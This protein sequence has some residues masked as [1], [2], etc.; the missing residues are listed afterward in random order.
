MTHDRT[1]RALILT[2]FS[3]LIVAVV[4]FAQT[5]ISL[6]SARSAGL[7]GAY[8]AIGDDV[9]SI[10]SN[11][12]GLM[13]LKRTQLVGSYTRYFSGA[14]IPTLQ[15][16]S[17][18][19]S[20]YNWSKFF[21]ALGVS[22]FNH[23][24]YNQQMGSLVIGRELWR[25]KR[26]AR[27]AAAVN[28]DLYRVDYNDVN[29]SD[30]FDPNDPL[31]NNG[32]SKMAYG[33]DFSL[34]AEYGPVSWGLR[35]YNLNEPEISL[36][37]GA[38]GGTLSRKVR[39]GLSYNIMD[40]VTPAIEV[41]VP[42]TSNPGVADKTSFALGAESWFVK[43]MIGA[44]MGFNSMLSS[45]HD[46]RG[47]LFTLG[48]SFRSRTDW[49]AGI[50]Y[51]LQ[52]PID[53]PVEVGQTHKISFG[54]G[55]HKPTRVIT[56]L[57]VV[58]SSVEAVPEHVTPG[59]EA[60][61]TLKI[62]NEGDMDAHDFPMS[63]YYFA[64]GKPFVAAR[65]TVDELLA[66]ETKE[67]VLKFRP[68]KSGYYD[69]FA[70]V[71]DKGDRAPAVH[72]KVLEYDLENNTGQTRLACFGPPVMMGKVRTS[73]DELEISTI[74]KVKEET[75][76]VPVIFFDK[77]SSSLD[78]GRFDATLR[79]I[80]NRLK[81]NPG[82]KIE[83]RG[84]YDPTTEADGGKD[85]ALARARKI[86][87]YFVSLG[88]NP[89]QLIVIESGYD[90]AAE[91][92]KNATP[93]YRSMISGENRSVQLSVRLDE[94]EHVCQYFYPEGNIQP[95]EEDYEGCLSALQ[96]LV[97]YLKEN[98]DVNVVFKGVAGCG[99]D[100]CNKEA[101][102]RAIEFRKRAQKAV[103]EWLGSRLLVLASEWVAEDEVARV[104]I[105]LNGD[106][107][108]FRPR[109]SATGRGSLEFSELGKMEITID[110]IASAVGLDSFAVT[111]VEDG[112]KE[113]FAV[114]DAGEGAPPRSIEWGGLGNSGQ[115]P[116]PGKKYLID[117]YAEDRFGQSI[118]AKSDPISVHV[119]EQEER[120]ELFIISFNFGKAEATSQYLEARVEALADKLIERAKYLGP[121][122]RI[123]ATVIGHTD[124]IGSA[125]A[126][127]E[128]SLERAKKEFDRLR[129]GIMN[130]LDLDSSE[131][132]DEWLKAHRV[133]LSYAGESY[134]DPMTVH[135][136]ENGYWHSEL[137]GDNAL[138]EGRLVNRRVVL[139]IL[140]IKR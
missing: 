122:V 5:D 18:Y 12:A 22:Y 93:E 35:A 118:D 131:E 33:G 121:N 62:A 84:Y 98:P 96:I 76:M 101:F 21:F 124:I 116:E 139:E 27:I 97:P 4:A 41:E 2:A 132:L 127:E 47:S 34:L 46:S 40:Y 102:D 134:N 129:Y 13:R 17:F 108:I 90:M 67:V 94:D 70:S 8:L 52:I 63:L 26:K 49:D 123:K 88:V 11:P 92:V 113:P 61:I 10:A 24:I 6:E 57:V 110:S 73:R 75:P 103:P 38:E 32:Y 135:R 44:R 107:L 45:D 3:V 60:N 140:T 87:D 23:D 133:E 25:H 58:P 104:E 64:D 68:E 77:A 79:T 28:I 78:K 14:N 16:G 126:N 138:P 39:T 42:V 71:N 50:D 1:N 128:L 86:K 100:N 137:I 91:H 56:D 95:S 120:K 99:E 111:V 19:F 51:A 74:S 112:A 89:K 55:M 83:L 136:W 59:S 106:A 29:F 130:I 69:L 65:T 9:N 54:I 66:G 20:P 15:E 114:L 30:D 37:A 82:V 81:K 7:G 117:V 53:S 36:R 109:G 48:L 119:K 85:L 72:N 43:K 31:F 105:L 115:P 80:A 125:K